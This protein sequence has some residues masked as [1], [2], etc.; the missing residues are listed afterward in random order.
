M[1]RHSLPLDIC[2]PGLCQDCLQA[3]KHW[4]EEIAQQVKAPA[5]KTN[6]QIAKINKRLL[7]QVVLSTPQAHVWFLSI[8][9]ISMSLLQKNLINTNFGSRATEV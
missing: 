6:G 3:R 7:Q 4:N 5:A 8:I 9:Y 2:Y 1:Y